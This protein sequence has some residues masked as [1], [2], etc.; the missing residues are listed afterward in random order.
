MV[1]RK[2][3]LQKKILN[4]H[5]N[6]IQPPLFLRFELLNP[7]NLK[8]FGDNMQMRFLTKNAIFTQKSHDL[9]K[10][11]QKLSKTAIFIFF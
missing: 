9:G 7:L 11:C 6:P 8:T 4:G 2:G 1:L 5:P 10:Y 3:R